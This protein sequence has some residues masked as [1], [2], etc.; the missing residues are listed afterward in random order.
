LRR[1]IADLH[2]AVRTSLWFVPSVMVIVSI[3][4]GQTL[5]SIDRRVDPEDLPGW[6]FGGGAGAA[7]EVLSTISSAM[8]QFT[9]LVFSITIVVLQLASSQ[10]SP[11]ILRQFLRDRSGQ[12]AMGI[13]VSTF[14]FTLIVLRS[15]RESL[16]NQE[17]FIPG[18][19]VSFAIVLVLVSVGFFIHYINDIAQSIRVV[20]LVGGVA[21]ETRGLIDKLYPESP[22]EAVVDKAPPEEVVDTIRAWRPGTLTS[23]DVERAVKLAGDH[24]CCLVLRPRVGDF[25]CEDEE[26]LEVRGPG[27]APKASD[28]HALLGVNIERTMQQDVAFG[29]R[30]L[31]DIA[32]RA[33]SPSLNDPTTAV[34]CLD[35]IHDLLRRLAHRHFPNGNHV[36]DSGTLRL[37]TQVTAWEEYVSLGLD[38]I[39]LYSRNSIQVT[40]RISSLL[41]DLLEVAPEGRKPILERQMQLLESMVEQQIADAWDRDNALTRDRQ[42]LGG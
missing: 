33:L 23:V 28:I 30:Q 12:F 22:E 21:E 14:T 2:E 16:D 38:E 40:R 42:G 13:F 6:L 9:A 1:R 26:I 11:R 39:R 17:S 34:Q 19:S 41:Q 36:D 31:V 25:V 37:V 27:P 5:V 32:E 8:M 7:R 29:F 10:Y 35:H 24:D 18:I 20:K 15:V 4:L 3:A